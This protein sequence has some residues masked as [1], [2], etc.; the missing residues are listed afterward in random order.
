MLRERTASSLRDHAWSA[1]GEHADL[2]DASA[3]TLRAIFGMISLIA[4]DIL[5]LDR[6]IG[7]LEED[8]ATLDER[9]ADE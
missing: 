8:W 6:R 1:L 9:G 4:A 3:E 5:D 7:K 2:S